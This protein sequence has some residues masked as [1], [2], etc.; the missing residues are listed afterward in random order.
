M[1]WMAVR[2]ASF[3]PANVGAQ[4]V[5]ISSMSAI[6]ELVSQGSHETNAVEQSMLSLSIYLSI[7]LS[8]Y[9]SV[10]LSIYLSIYTYI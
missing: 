8:I 1:L 7:H 4:I 10:Y 2:V 6:L 9:L 3:M 5:V